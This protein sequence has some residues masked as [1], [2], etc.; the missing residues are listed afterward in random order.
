MNNTIVFICEF[1]S[2]KSVLAAQWFSKLAAE[3]ELDLHGVSRGTNP[4]T[5]VPGRIRA[6]LLSA[7]I[8]I[9]N[10]AP[11]KLAPEDRS[12]A[13]MI[14]SFTDEPLEPIGNVPVRSWADVPALSEDFDVASEQIRTRVRALVEE[15]SHS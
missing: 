6:E 14:V 5:E 1:G 15:L 11:Q 2:K 9:G 12:T 8:D 7:G 4:D 13:R 3:R 10:A